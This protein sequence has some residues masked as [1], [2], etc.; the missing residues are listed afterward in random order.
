MLEAWDL[1]GNAGSQNTSGERA[2]QIIDK[3]RNSIARLI[4]A[5]PA[6]IFFTSG[7][8]E[9]NNLALLGA[10]ATAGR[11][12]PQ[13]RRLVM[14]AIEH[15][16]V[17]EPMIQLEAQGYSVSVAPVDTRGQL[18]LEAF[19]TLMGDDVLM[20]SI[21]MVNNET[22]VIQPIADAARLA[23]A[24]GALFHSDGA[25]AA[26]KIEIDVMHLDVDYLSLSAHKC[27]GPMGV[28][29]LYVAAGA[30]KPKPLMFGGGQ[31]GAVRPGTEP[32]ALIAGFGAA[33][34]VAHRTFTRDQHHGAET[35]EA[36]LTGLAEQRLRFDRVTDDAPVVAGSAAIAISGIDGDLLCGL[37]A[38]E[39]SLST[40]S[41]C[42]SGQLRTSHVLD[43]MR[44]SEQEARSVIRIF[45]SRYNT[46]AEIDEAVAHI[47]EAASRSALATGD[48]HQ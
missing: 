33:A 26:A 21:M 29:C 18:D 48:I 28:G 43:A 42:T 25:Q 5:S 37:V 19:A 17:L 31:Q 12:L 23:H 44:Y 34:D 3:G 1:P 16:A 4:G 32:V 22:G 30:P 6:E 38:R 2:A 11:V 24:A 47:V 10:T 20:A 35:V 40:G 7:A 46:R 13:R 9:A 36:L 27:Y 45:C 41:A 39:V 15:K 8:T 14:S